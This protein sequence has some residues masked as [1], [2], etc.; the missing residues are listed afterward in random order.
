MG[1]REM[2]REAGQDPK[3]FA[4]HSGKTRGATQ[5]SNQGSLAFQIYREKVEVGGV[6]NIIKGRRRRIQTRLSRAS[7]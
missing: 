5:L 6:Y 3:K 1:L 4:L 7:E 2:A